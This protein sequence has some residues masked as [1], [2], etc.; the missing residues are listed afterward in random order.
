QPARA[1][2]G[3]CRQRPTARARRH[4]ACAST[5]LERSVVSAVFSGL[6]SELDLTVDVLVEQVAE[7][8]GSPG[9]AG[10]RAEGAHRDEIAFLHFDPVAVKSVDGLALEHV[11]S[12]L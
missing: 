1:C 12:V 9:I 11:E 3:S 2:P 10:L 6:R 5:G 7:P 4:T 8:A